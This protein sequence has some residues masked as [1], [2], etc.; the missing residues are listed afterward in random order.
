MS[1][2]K[3]YRGYKKELEEMNYVSELKCKK[4]I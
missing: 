1:I 2:T 4:D 3:E